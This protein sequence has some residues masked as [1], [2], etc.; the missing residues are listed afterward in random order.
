M[1][2]GFTLAEI[3]IVLG[4]F[5]ILAVMI[6]PT[7]VHESTDSREL[8]YKLQKSYD[9][10]NQVAII[11]ATENNGELKNLCKNDDLNCLKDKFAEKL[12]YKKSC[13]TGIDSIN[14][15]WHDDIKSP[16][17]SLDGTSD[18]TAF[19]PKT[20]SILLSSG[21]LLK[22]NS[23]DK[24]CPDG[25][26]GKIYVDVNGFRP[27]NV[28]GKD[29]FGMYLNSA[30]IV[31]IG[32]LSTESTSCSKGNISSSIACTAKFVSTEDLSDIPS[33]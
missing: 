22:F 19:V 8:I 7:T 23:Y 27:P 21:A 29:V 18:K 24:T 1:K 15:C 30:G 25:L 4:V 28:A 10:L 11:L 6:V 20:A 3:L 31:P 26:C 16:V 12:D 33:K 32:S 5:F 13:N 14:T 2:R 9:S 17:I